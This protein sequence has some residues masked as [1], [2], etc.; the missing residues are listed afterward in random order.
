MIGSP[1]GLGGRIRP[2]A[3][4]LRL[5]VGGRRVPRFRESGC[6]WDALAVQPPL[7]PAT[8]SE[9]DPSVGAVPRS[10]ALRHP[11]FA[12]PNALGPRLAH[13]VI[14]AVP[15]VSSLALLKAG[16]YCHSAREQNPER[17]EPPAPARSNR[18]PPIV[19]SVV[20]VVTRRLDRIAIP[21]RSRAS[22][23]WTFAVWIVLTIHGD[24]LDRNRG[25]FRNGLH[26]AVS[27]RSAQSQ[28]GTTN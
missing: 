10:L 21:A 6:G 18:E 24:E 22:R 8:G 15:L 28:S 5:A 3:A 1:R 26:A 14:P 27:G 12:V 23:P 13:E 17:E 19:Q 20:R 11:A 7:L 25:R 16:D 2:E 9:R 4:V